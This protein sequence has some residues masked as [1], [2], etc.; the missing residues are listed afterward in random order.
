MTGMGNT[1]VLL[2]C[3]S[4]RAQT[5][6]VNPRL[7]ELGQRLKAKKWCSS[8][9]AFIGSENSESASAALADYVDESLFAQSEALA[10]YNPELYCA[11]VVDL[12]RDLQPKLVLLGN[13]FLGIDIAGRLS[14]RLKSGF[15][16]NCIDVDVDAE[17]GLFF[18]RPV[19]RSKLI[20]RI[21]ATVNKLI[22]ATMQS[23][24]AVPPKNPTP[25]KTR[26]VEVRPNGDRQKIRALRLLEP[27][28]AANDITKADI[29]V[30]GGRGVG[31]KDNFK[32]I[33]NLAAA[34]GGAAG[35]SRPLVDMGWVDSSIQ[36]GMSGK[37]VKPKLYI[38]CGI[39]GAMEHLEGMKNSRIIVAIN[40]DRNAPIFGVAN[41][42]IVGDLNEIVP[43]LFNRAA[44]LAKAARS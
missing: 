17:G 2:L 15:L 36:V 20:A 40:K 37:T 29:I 13:T 42:G 33:E 22:I 41:Y 31:E 7:I 34:M 25:G 35:A 23:A 21:E 5:E 4:G 38:A 30:A 24:E 11:I 6:L 26:G 14:R 27:Q 12:I 8:I 19:Y 10:N 3:E 44:E 39:S 9:R 18:Q 16:A 28:S 1:D 43:E 32:L